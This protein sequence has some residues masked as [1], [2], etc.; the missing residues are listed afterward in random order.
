MGVDTFLQGSS[1]EL[2]GK[3]ISGADTAPYD[4]NSNEWKQAEARLAQYERINSMSVS[5]LASSISGGSILSG[6]QA[7]RD[8]Q[9]YNP[10]KYQQLQDYQ[11]KEDALKQINMI[12]S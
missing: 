6:S 5:Q 8:L 10:E 9:M 12:A 4:H 11:K 7:M 3:M 2:F 1:T